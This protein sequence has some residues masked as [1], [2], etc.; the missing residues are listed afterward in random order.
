[1]R[2]SSTRSFSA[3]NQGGSLERRR[4]E[5]QRKIIT[6]AIAVVALLIAV[7]SFLILG[8]I[9]GWFDKTEPDPNK[10]GG[11]TI[12]YEEK[13][14]SSADIHKGE[15]LLIN[16]AFP[17]V[18][19]ETNDN[20]L[21][22]YSHRNQHDYVTAGGENKKTYSYYTQSGD[23]TCAKLEANALAAFN[24]WADDFYRATNEIDLFVFDEDG[25][26]S[27]SYQ[28]ELYAA[29]PLKYTPAGQTEHHLGRSIDL[30]IY[31]L[32]G[33]RYKLDDE[34][35][36]GTYSWLFKN[37]HKYGFVHRYP[38]D[39]AGV[40]GVSNEQYMFR[41]VGVAHA[42]Y[43]YQNNLSLEEYL[44]LLCD[45]HL[46]EGEHLKIEGADGK[47]YEVYYVKA[48]TDSVTTVNVPKADDP[49]V[50]SYEISGDNKSGFIVTVTLKDK[51]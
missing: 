44:D 47:S 26:R 46:Y 51:E 7:F 37:A 13:L 25:Y 28:A 22:L 15:L 36:A 48:S 43:M 35:V 49:S 14:I 8:E 45:S 21:D 18:F 4:K 17:Y 11:S 42:T 3:V 2:N 33:N 9:F 10:N 38:T 1:M 19:P 23:K 40:T 24:K 39:K 31:T 50:E 20:F 5:K 34:S 16:S 41:Y 30:Y 27:N 29:D 12:S 6:A 32:E